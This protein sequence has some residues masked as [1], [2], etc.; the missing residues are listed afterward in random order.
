MQSKRNKK[1]SGQSSEV[2]SSRVVDQQSEKG[3]DPNWQDA[4][5]PNV[6]PSK[7]SSVDE[8]EPLY[9][10]SL[11]TQSTKQVDTLLTKRRRPH[12]GCASCGDDNDFM[13]QIEVPLPEVLCQMFKCLLRS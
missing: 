5:N 3:S 1:S 2:A 9:S 12:H 10:A 8:S 13:V 7:F 6:P 11:A 4:S